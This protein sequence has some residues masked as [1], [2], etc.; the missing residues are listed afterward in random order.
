MHAGTAVHACH[1]GRAHPPRG[2]VTSRVARG[3]EHGSDGSARPFRGSDGATRPFCG[4]EWHHLSP[5]SPLCGR[6]IFSQFFS[7]HVYKRKRLKTK[8]YI[9]I[10]FPHPLSSFLCILPPSLS[11][12]C[13]A[14]GVVWAEW[15]RTKP[16]G[17]SGPATNHSDGR[18]ATNHSGA[19]CSPPP[20][21]RT[22]RHRHH[23]RRRWRC[24]PWR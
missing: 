18:P 2:T 19:V 12:S 24:R 16:A 13:E 11:L 17:R 21:P 8:V 14:G 20:A 5:A 1:A 9:Q 3:S 4:S 7:M 10:L 23:P 15:R 6:G 22:R